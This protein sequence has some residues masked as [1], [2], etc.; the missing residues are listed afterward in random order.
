MN[1]DL[2]NTANPEF[3]QLMNGLEL[4]IAALDSGAPSIVGNIQY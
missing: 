2:L 4:G 1:F 3:V